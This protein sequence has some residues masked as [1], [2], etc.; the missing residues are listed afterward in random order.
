MPLLEPPFDAIIADPPYGQTACSWDSIIPLEPLWAEYKRL[1]KG[2]GAVV[3]FG[4]QPFTSRLVMSNLDWFKYE[5]VWDKKLAGNIFLC[6]YQPLKIHESVLVFGG[7]IYNPQIVPRKEIRKYKDKYGGG[8]SFGKKGTGNKLHIL[9]NKQPTSIIEFSNA[10]RNGDHPT[11][12]PVALMSYLIRTYTNPGEIILDNTMGSGT[13]LVAAKNEGR[14]AVGIEISEE[15]CQIAVDRLTNTK[16][17]SSP[18]GKVKAQ[19]LELMG[20][21]KGLT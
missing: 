19:Q 7:N 10:Q 11:Q 6:D 1:I 8:E 4:S 17:I 21:V 18:N 2:N 16:Y 5:W 12:K 15:Y 13:T 3:L 20:G 9:T 14:R